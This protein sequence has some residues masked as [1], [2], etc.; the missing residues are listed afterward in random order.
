MG[1]W[2]DIKVRGIL[3]SD[4]HDDKDIVILGRIVNWTNTG[5]RYQADPKHRELILNY[6][7]LG[8]DSGPLKS[9]GEKEREDGEGESEE[10]SKE[11]AKVYRGLSATLSFL[12][13]D[14][15]DL[16]F[17]T[18]SAAR[19]MSAPR[20]SSWKILNK[21]DRYLVGREAVVWEFKW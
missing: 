5:I 2:F 4:Q 9:S 10:L 17:G 14:C 8:E 21:L 12:S 1:S 15:P 16:Q 20:I 13:L 11:E 6:F 18:K 3:G 19:E 7:G